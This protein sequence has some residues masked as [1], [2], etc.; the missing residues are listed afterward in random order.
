MK[1]GNGYSHALTFLSRRTPK[2][3]PYLDHMIVCMISRGT[4]RIENHFHIRLAM[5]SQPSLFE[6][7]ALLHS[8]FCILRDGVAMR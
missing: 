6:N 8:N 5:R 3:A 7:D 2:S 1:S 4:Y